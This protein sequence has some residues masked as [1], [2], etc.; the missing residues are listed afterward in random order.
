MDEEIMGKSVQLLTYKVSDD[1]V[2][3]SIVFT[4]LSE[5]DR[6]QYHC[7][8]LLCHLNVP[9]YSYG[10]SRKKIEFKDWLGLTFQKEAF[11]KVTAQKSCVYFLFSVNS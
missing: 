11:I 5:I 3:G 1:P 7:L 8:L 9:V 4:H 2:I 10:I 6:T